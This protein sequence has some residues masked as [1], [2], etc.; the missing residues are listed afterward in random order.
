MLDWG[1][2]IVLITG[3]SSQSLFTL[4]FIEPPTQELPELGSYSQT[5]WRSAMSRLSFSTSTPSSPRTVRVLQRTHHRHLFANRVSDNITY[6]KCDVSKLE[7]VEA[8]AKRVIEEVSYCC[9]PFRFT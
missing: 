9:P 2:Q 8:V 3:G 7:E 1:E 4:V 6:Y 5:L